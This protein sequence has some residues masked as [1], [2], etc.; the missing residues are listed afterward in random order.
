MIGRRL[1]SFFA[2]G[3]GI[4]VAVVACAS[5]SEEPAGGGPSGCPQGQTQCGVDGACVDLMQSSLNCGECGKACPTAASCV[6][7]TCQCGAGRTEC[8][9]ACV[10]LQGDGIN[11]G[12]CGVAC[13]T[14]TF[15]SAGVCATSCAGGMLACGASCVDVQTNP[16]HC[17][18]CNVACSPGQSC[19]A[20]TCACPAGEELCGGAC[21]AVGTD[22][23]N[24][25]GCGIVCGAGQSCEAGI[26]VGGIGT[27]GAGTGGAGTG[28]VGTG[29]VGTG[30]AGTGGQPP[31]GDVFTIEASLSSAI[32]TVGIVNWSASVPI[33]SAHIDFG[34]D[35]SAWE[36]QAPVPSATQSGNRT[37]LLGM[38]PATTYSFQ[39]VGQGGGQTYTSGVQEITTGQ[40]RSGLPSVTVDAPGASEGFTTV[41]VFGLAFGPTDQKS[42]TYIIDQDGDRVWWYQGSGGV[43]C[44]RSRM[45]YDGQY[46]WIANGNVPGPSNGT[47]VRVGMDGL[48]E[49]SYS[50]PNRHHDIAVLPDESIVY[51]EYENGDAQGCDVVKTLNPETEA[52]ATVYQVSQAGGGG[53]NC[54][55]NAINW[56]P[57]QNLFTLSVLNWNSIIAFTREGSLEWVLGGSAS[58]YSGASWNAQH[59]HHLLG[60]TILLFNNQGSNGGSSILEYQLNGNQAQV[61]WDYSSGHA[62]NQMGDVKRLSPSGHTL[63]TYSN[64]GVIQEVDASQQLIQE[65]T[66]DQIGYSVRRR[67]LYGAPPP[68]AD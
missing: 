42:W 66:T 48:D 53:G 65:I 50:V 38:K 24:C 59:Q 13:Q 52:T 55:S 21:T 8:S 28:G 27:G 33:D 68:Y 49:R 22:G 58:T 39:I 31:T 37:L 32:S 9:G 19:T 57:D 23:S 17:G 36:Y 46:M 43:D 60:G 10:D 54:H 40:I 25:G 35:A 16:D 30:G 44:V 5:A 56:W 62:S 29:G 7:G 26:C 6:A 45:S 64:Q 2:S 41:C 63:V 20:G 18:N 67:T 1:L 3:C 11:C 14:G 34:R 15:C 61:I 47:L 4:A 12:G 51:F